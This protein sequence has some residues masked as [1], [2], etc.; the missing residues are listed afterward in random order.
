MDV[1]ILPLIRVLARYLQSSD[2][3]LMKLFSIEKIRK[4]DLKITEAKQGKHIV[5]HR[6]YEE[7]VMRG[8]NPSIFEHTDPQK[9]LTEYGGT[10][11]KGWRC[12]E[13]VIGFDGYVEIVDFKQFIGYSVEE[14]TG[15]KTATTMGKIHYAKD[16]AHIV[17]FVKR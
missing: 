16:G 13:T 7:L 12:F 1:A 2:T 9:L 6:N 4:G 14:L 10:G 3:Q 5:G 11:V 8:K 15:I 17:P